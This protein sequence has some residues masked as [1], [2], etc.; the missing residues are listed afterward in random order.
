MEWV[1]VELN[2]PFSFLMALY[3]RV[4]HPHHSLSYPGEFGNGEVEHT[5]TVTMITVVPGSH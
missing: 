1:K 2:G 3:C 5:S 4:S